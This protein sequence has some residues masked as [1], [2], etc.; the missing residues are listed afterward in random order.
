MSQPVDEQLWHDSP[1]RIDL[2]IIVYRDIIRD[3][4]ELA[5]EN[6][7]DAKTLRALASAYI[8]TRYLCIYA[9]WA[10]QGYNRGEEKPK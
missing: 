9:A 5:K 1:D 10:A 3:A 4:E 6:D 2:P 7:M 8:S